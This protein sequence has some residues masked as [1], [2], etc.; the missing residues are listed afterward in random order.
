MFVFFFLLAVLPC[1]AYPGQQIESTS[2]A[3]K[4]IVV[5]A[6]VL[7]A[8]VGASPAATPPRPR[9]AAPTAPV[10]DLGYA[11]YQG[12]YN[13]TVDTIVYKGLVTLLY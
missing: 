6:T 8:G 3:F 1:L 10:V 11:K 7:L 12:Y 2:M 13:S 4:T 9:A 5:L